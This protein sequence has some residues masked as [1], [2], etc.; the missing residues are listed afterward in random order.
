MTLFK[1][2]HAFRAFRTF[3]VGAFLIAGAAAWS[4][5]IAQPTR[6]IPLPGIG[7]G[8]DVSAIQFDGRGLM[9]FDNH[10]M[11]DDRAYPVAMVLIDFS[12]ERN[13]GLLGGYRSMVHTVAVDCARRRAQTIQDRLYA[14]PGAKERTA[15]MGTVALWKWDPAQ[16]TQPAL[17]RPLLAQVCKN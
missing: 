16:T 17:A 3:R 13:A 6:W 4:A 7:A 14:Q 8:N 5:A 15:I 2:M 12:R 11:D 1:P 9:E 10:N